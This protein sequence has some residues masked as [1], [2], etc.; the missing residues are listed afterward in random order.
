[1]SALQELEEVQL[2]QAMFMDDLVLD[3][4][5]GQLLGKFELD[6]K[7]N[8]A[9]NEDACFIRCRMIIKLDKQVG[10]M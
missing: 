6:L 3:E 9:D 8:T 7:P 4:S 5:D 10:F 2:L 1:M